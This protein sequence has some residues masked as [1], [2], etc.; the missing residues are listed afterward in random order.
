[1][2]LPASPEGLHHPYLSLLFD[3]D[4]LSF[5]GGRSLA[6]PGGAQRLLLVYAQK[7]GGPYGN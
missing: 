2:A 3:F 6:T 7:A 1:M 4:F 5:W